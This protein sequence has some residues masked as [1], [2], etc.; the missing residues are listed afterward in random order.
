MSQ[1]YVDNKLMNKA[2]FRYY[3][4]SVYFIHHVRHIQAKAN[5]FQLWTVKQYSVH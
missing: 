4:Y 2:I 3:S 5:M 1:E